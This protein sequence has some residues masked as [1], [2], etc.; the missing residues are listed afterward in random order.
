ME[1]CSPDNDHQEGHQV[2]NIHGILAA[3]GYQVAFGYVQGNVQGS[4][5]LS[6]IQ[7]I[8]VINRVVV[9]LKGALDLVD[10]FQR[11]VYKEFQLRNPSQLVTG[12]LRQFVF[13]QRLVRANALKQFFTFFMRKKAD[14]HLGNRKV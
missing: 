4:A 5:F 10:I 7:K 3:F 13:D 12:A 6:F 2:N 9:A 8:R 1:G 11:I 14:I